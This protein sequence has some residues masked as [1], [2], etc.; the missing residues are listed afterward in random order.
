MNEA[1]KEQGGVEN[2]QA[3]IRVNDRRRFDRDGNVRAEAP[4]P[5]SGEES[6]AEGLPPS[7][8]HPA[9]DAESVQLR[10]ELEAARKRVDEL[11]RAFQALSNDREEFKQR[12][13]RER[14][15]MLEVEKGHVAL[16]LLEVL[17]ELDLSLEASNKDDSPLARGVRLIRDGI[18]SRVQAMGI[19]RFDLAGQIFDPNLAEAADVEITTV[20]ADDQKVVSVIRAGYRLKERVIRP[21]RVRV[22]KYVAPAEA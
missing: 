4:A 19:E 3:P 18:L 8:A 9:E 12:L 10:Q 13:A 7:L 11:A 5:P 14:E 15:R 1:E 2:D 17:D 20:P 6:P 16:V 21:A 22:A